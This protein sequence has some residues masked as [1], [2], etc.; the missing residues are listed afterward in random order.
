[1][2]EKVLEEE[3]AYEADSVRLR[4]TLHSEGLWIRVEPIILPTW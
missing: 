1:M 4:T 3:F 2:N